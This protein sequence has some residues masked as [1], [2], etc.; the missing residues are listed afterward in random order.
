MYVHDL[1]FATF[2]TPLYRALPSTRQT[3]SRAHSCA[4]DHFFSF[5]RPG[6]LILKMPNSLFPI[7]LSRSR[8]LNQRG[9]HHTSYRF[10]CYSRHCSGGTDLQYKVSQAKAEAFAKIPSAVYRS[11]KRQGL[12]QL[13]HQC[14]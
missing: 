6:R 12:K 11:E 7:P 1:L 9:Y 2:N 3:D 14:S 4:V 5:A 10:E 8:R 13:C